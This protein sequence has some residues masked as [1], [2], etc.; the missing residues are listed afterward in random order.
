MSTTG[1]PTKRRKFKAE[2]QQVLDIL[3]HSLYTEQEIFLRELISNASDALNRFKLEALTQGDVVDPSAELGIWIDTDPEANTITIRDTGIGMTQEEMAENL[4]TIAHSGAKEFIK[5][6]QEAEKAE[7]AKDVIGQFGVGFYSVFMVA[8]EVTVTSRPYLPDAEAAM[9]RS[10]GAG[11][12]EIGPAEKADR[13]TLITIKLNEEAKEFTEPYRLRQIVKRHSDFVPFPIYIKETVDKEGEQTQAWKQTNQRTALWREMPK[14]VE[15]EQYK[16]FYQQLTFDFQ[17]PIKTIHFA[18]DMPLQ[19]YA[20]L[21]IP[22][23]RDYRV[24]QSE[25]DYGLKLYAR[26]VLIK[27]RFTEL[28]PPYLRFVEGV[29]DSE[30]LPLNVSRESVQVSPIIKKIKTALIGRVATEL[31]RLAEADKKAYQRFFKEFGPF[32]KEGAATGAEGHDRFTELLRFP[33]SMAESEGDWVSLDDYLARM[34]PDQKEI[35]YL[36]GDDLSVVSKSAHLE[37]FKKHDLEV[38]YLTDPMDSFML[39]GLSEYQGKPLKNIDDAD[40]ELPEEDTPEEQEETSDSDEAIKKLIAKFKEVLGEGVE[41]VRESKVLTDHACRLVNPSGSGTTSFQR[42]QRMMGKDYQVPK[43]I[44]E[45]NRKSELIQ[46]LAQ[47]F[48]SNPQDPVVPVLVE[49]LYENELLMEGIHPNPAEMIPRLQKLMAE[50][51]KK[52]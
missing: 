29:V 42:V 25:T 35:Y 8:D 36:L 21:F 33:S 20:L 5:A 52:A 43:K 47:R 3:I 9:W 32:L 50:A 15:D 12:Y 37:Y 39:M 41:D 31:K 23:R 10:K 19:F 16:A 26:K 11:T 34:K 2:T 30:D 14:D 13:G 7:A 4:G 49:Q 24:F 44:L 38:L 48:E 22:S 46:N 45:I 40:L 18:A 6:L 51:S 1:Q 27:E 17:E 28:L